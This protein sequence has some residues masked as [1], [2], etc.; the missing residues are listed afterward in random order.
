MYFFGNESSTE[1]ASLVA[2]QMPSPA[3]YIVTK[4]ESR[5]AMDVCEP[6]VLQFMTETDR[7]I[8]KNEILL[9][10]ENIRDLFDSVSTD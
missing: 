9:R 1:V 3:D 2:Y 6:K 8:N 7:T 10:V 4:D 5:S